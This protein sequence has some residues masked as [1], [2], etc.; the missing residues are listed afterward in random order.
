LGYALRLTKTSL[1]GVFVA[2]VIVA[3]AGYYLLVPSQ[4][5]VDTNDAK[6]IPEPLVE[7]AEVV[8]NQG[9]VMASDS[10]NGD[11]VETERQ[12]EESDIVEQLDVTVER[13][14]LMI[15]ERFHADADQTQFVILNRA[16]FLEQLRFSPAYMYAESGNT[17]P[18]LLPVD[19]VDFSMGLFGDQLYALQ[20]AEVTI[21]DVA[22]SKHLIIEG[23]VAGGGVFRFSALENGTLQSGLIYT[24][25][26]YIRLHTWKISNATLVAA[27]SSATAER[28]RAPID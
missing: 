3:L 27:Y 10:A 6:L 8:E 18:P 12:I 26:S 24:S 11:D 20:V 2:V 16:K 1:A 9:N 13:E 23:T 17:P 15:A 19:H 22:G 21:S 25:D 14:V 5:Y 4:E 28:L 7:I